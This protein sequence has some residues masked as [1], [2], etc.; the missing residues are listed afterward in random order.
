[1]DI[2]PYYITLNLESETS[3]AT[4]EETIPI[5]LP[6]EMA[7]A[8]HQKSRVQ[9]QRSFLQGDGESCVAFWKKLHEH[10]PSLP[11][12]AKSNNELS[13]TLPIMYHVDGAEVHRNSEH[14]QFSWSS[15]FG[16]GDAWD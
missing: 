1:M 6:F 7:H 14:Y 11:T 4:H 13:M 8:I 16:G 3:V 9:F 2:E 15:F 12:A 5:L 10:F